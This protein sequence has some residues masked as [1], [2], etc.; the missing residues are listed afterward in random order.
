MITKSKKE[1]N[2][3][4]KN[5]LRKNKGS[6]SISVVSEMF[7]VHQQTIRLYEKEGLISPNRSS[8]NTRKFTEDDVNQLEEVIYLTH[9]LGVNLAGVGIILKLQK[10]I[11]KMQEE[12]NSIFEQTKKS[13]SD[14][15]VS[16][17]L[18]TK[19]YIDKLLEIKK[20]RVNQNLDNAISD[21]TSQHDIMKKL[22]E[23]NKMMEEEIN[24]DED[25]SEEN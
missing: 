14:D 7:G 16:F 20:N 25:S 12:V 24:F 15:S 13:L 23:L 3:E 18:D 4:K 1:K 22:S 5:D 8:G 21:N 19:K 11:R 2:K 10:K 6:Y 9:K 17:K